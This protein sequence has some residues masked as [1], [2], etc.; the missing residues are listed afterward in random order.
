VGALLDSVVRVPVS[1]PTG[2]VLLSPSVDGDGNGNGDGD[3]DGDGDNTTA[4]MLLQPGDGVVRED[5]TQDFQ[6]TPL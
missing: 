6:V 1:L 2:M 4:V 3:G 5:G